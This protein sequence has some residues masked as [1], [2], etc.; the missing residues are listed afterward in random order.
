MAAV[1][2]GKYGGEGGIRTPGTLASTSH[3]ECDAIDHSATSPQNGCFPWS[4]ALLAEV[5]RAA[6][7]FSGGR[8]DE[9]MGAFSLG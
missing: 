6:N 2:E 1:S 3:F 7:P 8:A 5:Y 4:W 9:G